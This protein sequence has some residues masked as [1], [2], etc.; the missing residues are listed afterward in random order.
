MTSEGIREAYRSLAEA[1]TSAGLGWILHQVEERVRDGRPV[2]KEARIFKDEEPDQ[3]V[4]A[5]DGGAETARRPGKPTLM[6]T[7]EPWTDDY[8]LQ[9]L[10]DAIRHAIIH[11]ADVETEQLRLLRRY[12]DI[13]AVQ[14]APDENAIE[15]RSLT[16]EGL[17]RQ[18]VKQLAE[19]LDALDREVRA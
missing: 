19:L 14:F 9:F 18:Q 15:R 2:E 1:L 4:L 13:K 12:D 6:M 7:L 10:I 17:E 11:A 3:H 5:I 16:I 8:R